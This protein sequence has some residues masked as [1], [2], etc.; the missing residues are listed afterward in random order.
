MLNWEIKNKC[1]LECS[2]E[3]QREGKHTNQLR[4]NT[5]ERN[6]KQSPGWNPRGHKESWWLRTF[7]NA[8]KSRILSPGNGLTDEIGYWR[9]YSV[10]KRKNPHLNASEDISEHQRRNRNEPHS[11]E[12]SQELGKG[13]LATSACKK[14]LHFWGKEKVKPHISQALWVWVQAC[15]KS[16]KDQQAYN[17]MHRRLQDAR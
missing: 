3:R 4:G 9:W 16:C 5:E 11:D 6:R 7:W 8:K 1:C 17:H 12:Q 14:A 13:A 2:L 15:R 10:D